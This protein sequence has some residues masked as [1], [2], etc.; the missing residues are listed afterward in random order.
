MSRRYSSCRSFSSPNI[1]S[2]S[3]SEK[4]M[5]A[6]SGVRSS[7]DMF[8]RNSDLCWLATSS[9]AVGLLQLLEQAD[10]LD[11][12]DGLVGE[13]LQQSDLL[14]GERPDLHPPQE[15][16]P[17]GNPFADQRHGQ[18]GAVAACLGMTLYGVGERK[19]CFGELLDVVDV[20]RPS[21][22]NGPSCDRALERVPL[23][24]PGSSGGARNSDGSGLP[25]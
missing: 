10:V 24:P 17:D 22:A 13:R 7:C 5:I 19:L 18:H 12:D 23:P 4:P 2:I 9:G 15:D 14:L 1:R 3:T 8:A 25:P 20:D 16:R 11:G 21:L 6:L